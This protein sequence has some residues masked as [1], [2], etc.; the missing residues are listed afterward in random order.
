MN[1]IDAA[2]ENL[3]RA[4]ATIPAPLEI[5]G[6][7]HC[8]DDKN[9][10]VLLR[11]NLRELAPED[12][13]SYASSAFLTVGDVQ[14]YLYF[15]PRILEISIKDSSWWPDI[16]VTGRA[17]NETNVKNWPADQEQALS[18]FFGSVIASFVES[19]DRDDY[20]YIDDWLC[21]AGRAG[22]DVCPLLKIVE[23]TP[24][25]LFH[26]VTENAISLDKGKLSNHFW[27]PGDKGR[28]QIIAWM[29]SDEVKRIHQEV[30]RGAK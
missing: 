4:F 10:D 16:E 13:S 19:P 8:I 7:A 1:A 24:D 9:I 21:A 23:Q 30:L 14:D 3:Y 12:L 22:L 15:L 29:R 5:D 20:Y 26:Y 11:T 2:V 28:D 27:E 25:A 18:D 17:L 6:C